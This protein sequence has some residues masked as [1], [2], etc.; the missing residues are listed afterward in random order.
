MVRLGDFCCDLVSGY[1]G[2][3]MGRA[4]YATGC[5][6]VLLVPAKLTDDGK[7][8]EGEWFDDI[9]VG[10]IAQGQGGR[11][12]NNLMEFRERVLQAGQTQ[13]VY[14]A[15]RDEKAPPTR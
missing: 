4:E 2:V 13:G 6:Q 12:G 10:I 7:R 5:T 8:P 11:A 15:G 1:E 9:R 3:C 14:A